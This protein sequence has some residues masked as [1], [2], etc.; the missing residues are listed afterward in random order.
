MAQGKDKKKNS[1]NKQKQELDRVKIA[2]VKT[3][4]DQVAEDEP[5]KIS[6]K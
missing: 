3:I 1:K 6:A 5:H 2:S 4:E